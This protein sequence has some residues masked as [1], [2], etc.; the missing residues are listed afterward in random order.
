MIPENIDNKSAETESNSNSML[1]EIEA[2][3][4]G[5]LME[6]QRTTPDAYPL[7]CNSLLL[8]CNQKTS[9]EPVMELSETEVLDTLMTLQKRAL[10][11]V[12]FGSRADKYDQRLSRELHLNDAEHAIFCLMMLRGPQTFNELLT[13]TRRLYDFANDEELQKLL[14]KLL[15]RTKPLIK[16]M[17]HQSGQREVRYMHL[18]SGEPIN[19][20][21]TSAKDSLTSSNSLS[22]SDS[23]TNTNID[24]HSSPD[25]LVARIEELEKQVAWLMEHSE[26]KG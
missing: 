20:A 22:P 4:L 19:H 3:I 5:S 18:L 9:R 14:D 7:T 2:R 13:R 1:N 23:S 25:E 12:E 16:I 8:A 24:E 10:V 6:K 15:N 11:K 21:S 17:P 26:S